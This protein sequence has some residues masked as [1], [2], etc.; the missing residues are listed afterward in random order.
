MSQ[1]QN[2]NWVDRQGFATASL[3]YR[4][5]TSLHWSL[6]QFTPASMEV[7]PHNVG[8]RFFSVGVLLFALIIFSS[9]VSSIT[10]AMTRMRNLNSDNN[11]NLSKLRRYLRD[12]KV[13]AKL[14]IRIKRYVEH[15]IAETQ[16]RIQ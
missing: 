7:I 3:E 16:Q 15:T 6:T 10:A 14:A 1:V 13:S 4:Y 9:F 5:A 8:E 2:P 12:H 11:N